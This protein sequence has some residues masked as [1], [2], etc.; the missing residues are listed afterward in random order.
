MVYYPLDLYRTILWQLFTLEHAE[1][2]FREVMT[3]VFALK[4]PL[5]L[6]SLSTVDS[7]LPRPVPEG[8][9]HH[10]DHG[11]IGRWSSR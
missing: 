5:P 4:E 10:P 3:V 6:S 2:R 1:H 11:I 9:R 7:L 8:P